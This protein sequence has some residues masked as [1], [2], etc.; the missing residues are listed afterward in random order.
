MSMAHWA[1][2]PWR[3]SPRTYKLTHL[4]HF[5]QSQ[6]FE[7]KTGWHMQSPARSQCFLPMMSAWR[8]ISQ[9]GALALETN[10]LACLKQRWATRSSFADLPIN[11]LNHSDR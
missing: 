2:R 7:R 10:I 8:L 1:K 6:S 5:A 3:N 9:R 4:A 11:A